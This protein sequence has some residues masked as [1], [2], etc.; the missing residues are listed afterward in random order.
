ME[1][2]EAQMELTTKTG[3]DVANEVKREFGDEDGIQINDA[4][5]VKWI[6][7]A[8]RK[9]V[10]VNPILQKRSLKDTVAGQQAYAYPA[11]RIQYIQSLSFAGY[12]L[13]GLSYAESQ[14]YIM[15]NG[16]GTQT[17]ETPVIWWQWAQSIYLWPVPTKAVVGGITM[18]YVAIP[19]DLAIIG[20]P[21]ALPDRYFDSV[22][23]QVMMRAHL[24]NEDWE[25]ANFSRGQFGESLAQL[26]EQENRMRLATY[27]TVSVREEDM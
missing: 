7:S 1:D 14:D 19:T 2:G 15:K 20:D 5:I 18:D 10:A 3:T 24:V 17:G 6:N 26:S 12:P 9:I 25:A 27:P 11:D 16:N 21:L 22:V 8:Q 23:E 4:D 13:I